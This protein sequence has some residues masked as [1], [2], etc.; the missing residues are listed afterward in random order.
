M[1]N[2]KKTQIFFLLHRHFKAF[3]EIMFLCK[4]NFNV[5]HSQVFLNKA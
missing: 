4:H 5:A 2:F 1:V 3:S